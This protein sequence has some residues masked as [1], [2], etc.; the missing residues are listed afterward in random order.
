MGLGS[1]LRV[2]EGGDEGVADPAVEG[3]SDSVL[4]LVGSEKYGW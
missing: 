4:P 1:N 2:G 3:P